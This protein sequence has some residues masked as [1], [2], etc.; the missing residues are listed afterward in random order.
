MAVLDAA[1]VEQWEA[2]EAAAKAGGEYADA[3]TA[4]LLRFLAK[5]G[6]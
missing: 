2:G 3:V 6:A 1:E 5:R 4:E